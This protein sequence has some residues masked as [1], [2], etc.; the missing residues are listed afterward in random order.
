MVMYGQYTKRGRIG[1]EV[2][3]IQDSSVVQLTIRND[4]IEENRK[5]R[6]I[7][8]LPPNE[9]L[10]VLDRREGPSHETIYMRIE[11]ETMELISVFH[12]TDCLLLRTI[13]LNEERNELVMEELNRSARC[14][15]LTWLNYQN[16]ESV[17]TINTHAKLSSDLTHKYLHC[18]LK[19]PKSPQGETHL[20]LC[21]W[22]RKRSL[23][24]HLLHY[25]GSVAMYG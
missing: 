11:L 16:T 6:L 23:Y 15:Q 12:R 20:L 5:I 7:R 22:Y 8:K 10:V 9:V 13:Y 14:F 17:E 18:L 4:N 2:F 19:Q 1:L 21:R 3:N 25:T 24:S